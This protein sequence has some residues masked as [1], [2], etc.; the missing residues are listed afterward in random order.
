[1]PDPTALRIL[2]A[3]LAEAEEAGWYELRLHR[4]AARAGV[5]LADVLRHYRDADAIANAWFARALA[6]MLAGEPPQGT[7][8]ERAEAILMRWF[9]AQ[10]AHRR[11]ACDMLRTKAHL[12]HPHHWVPMAFNLSRLMHWALDAAHLDSRGLARQAEEVGLTLAFLRALAAWRRDA[13]PGQERTRTVLRRSLGW[14][15]RLPRAG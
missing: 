14:L 15:D 7:P 8:A 12:S 9:A 10:T 3:A 1:M 6:A 13:T 5:P 4:V 11:T 2:D